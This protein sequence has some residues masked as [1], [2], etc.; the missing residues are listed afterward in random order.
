MAKYPNDSDKRISNVVALSPCAVATYLVN[1]PIQ[2]AAFDSARR[3]LSAPEIPRELAEIT[4]ADASA[5]KGRQLWHGPSNY[6]WNVTLKNYCDHNPAVC[7][8]YCEFYPDYCEDFCSR[9]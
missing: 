3:L 2:P 7:E 9:E 6:Y 8:K 1:D 4:E 5:P